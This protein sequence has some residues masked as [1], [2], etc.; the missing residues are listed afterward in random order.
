M[1]KSKFWVFSALLLTLAGM[2]EASKV[3]AATLST[4]PIAKYRY[5]YKTA[6]YYD[7]SISDHY[8]SV[9]SQAINA[10]KN[11][12]FAWKKAAD[13]SKTTLS[14]YAGND[15]SV[16]GYDT[17]NYNKSTGQIISSD[18]RINRTTFKKWNYSTSD[19]V[20]VAEHEL[21]HA[22]GLNHNS[23]GSIS[24]MNPANRY[25]PIEDCDVRG[26]NKRYSTVASFD[27]I[28]GMENQIVTI[29]VYDT[30]K[31]EIR[32]IKSKYD[33]TKK[34]LTISGLA[35]KGKKVVVKYGNKE[36]KT[37]SV[38]DGSFTTNVKFTGYKTFS[39]YAVDAH[40]KKVTSTTKLSSSK[41]AAKQPVALKTVR[42]KKGITATLSTEPNS[43]VSLYYLGKKISS[44]KTTSDKTKVFISAEELKGKKN[45]FTVK[46]FKKNK[47]VSQA[48]KIKINK[49]GIVSVINY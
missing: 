9:W 37:T 36:V 4:T 32:R 23:V 27:T 20:H 33:S 2:G 34:T 19:Q 25:Y 42:T 12:G 15:T 6:Y 29:T 47:K 45:Y 30:I 18:V 10:W 38:K 16:A 48:T 39:L 44:K 21:G 11:K 3:E 46:Q 35:T 22:L 17:V 40:G 24:V 31:P 26:M 13:H 7:K 41:Y 28:P 1:K 14:S 49:V 8:K 43:S 5:K